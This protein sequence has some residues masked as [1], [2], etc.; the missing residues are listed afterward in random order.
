MYHV[1]ILM[2]SA[3]YLCRGRVNKPWFLRV[4]FLHAWHNLR[5]KHGIAYDD[6]EREMHR[7][8]QEERD[9]EEQEKAHR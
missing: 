8:D 4:A 2:L 5:S 1:S 7:K 6:V 3:V 9:R